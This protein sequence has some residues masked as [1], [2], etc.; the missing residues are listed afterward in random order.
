MMQCSECNK[1]PA[2][3][4]LSQFINGEKTEIHVCEK[5]AQQ[6]G[7][8][9]P[10]EYSYSLHDLLSGLFSFGSSQID[11][12]SNGFFEQGKSLE[13]ERCHM[14]FSDFQRVGKFGCAKCY[15]TFTEK[16]DSIFRKV[17]SGN[18]KHHGKIPKREGAL[19]H[20]QKELAEYRL[21]LQELIGQEEFEQ[22]AVIRDKIKQIEK[23]ETGDGA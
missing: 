6:K 12:Q 7:Y 15:D 10:H 4:H 21:H 9:H 18:T 16:L 23:R 2:T 8:I 19:L 13:C 3:L 5:C 20:K 17:H 1:R 14:T 11:L 22:A